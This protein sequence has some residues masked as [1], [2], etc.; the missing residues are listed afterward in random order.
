MLD[1]YDQSGRLPVWEL[2][3]NETNCMI[4]YHSVSVLAD[5]LAKGYP[6]D[7]NRLLNAMTATANAPVF[8]IEIFD[9][10]GFLTIQ[11]EAES[12]SKTLEYSYDDACVS[13]SASYFGMD[14]IADMYRDRSAGY[15]SVTNVQTGLVAPRDNGHFLEET[16]PREVNSHFTEANAWQYSFSP[17]HDIE[18]WL[19]LIG[20]G[21]LKTGRLELENNLDELFTQSEQTTGRDQADITGLIGQYA[22]GNEPSH[23]IAY[24]YSAT[25]APHKGQKQVADIIAEFYGNTPDGLIGNEDCGQMSAWYVMATMGIYPLVP[26]KPEYILGTPIWDSLKLALPNGNSLLVKTNG[27]GPYI[28]TLNINKMSWNKPW[29]THLEL[30]EGG[31][32]EVDR[33]AKPTDWASKTPYTTNMNSNVAAAPILQG[34]R[35]FEE[36]AMVVFE[37]APEGYELELWNYDGNKV[38]IVNTN[39]FMVTESSQ[40]FAS[41]KNKQTGKK[42]QISSITLTKKP[43]QWKARITEGIPNPQYTAGGDAALVDGVKGELDWRKGNWIGVQEQDITVELSHPHPASVTQVNVQLLKD[44]RSWIGLPD[45]VSLWVREDKEWQLIGNKIIGEKALVNDESAIYD[46]EW[47]GLNLQGIDKL[48]LVMRNPGLLP[49]AHIS[50]GNQSFIF[51]DEITIVRK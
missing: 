47:T 29:L 42:G 28:Q 1:Q 5:A 34:P 38:E 24:L 48:K 8:G 7:G 6:I 18:G 22:H 13:W 27:D 25:H 3:A 37:L 17:V 46:V 19:K 32:W 33:S 12:V 31:T 21:S 39:Q 14:S 4:G 11:D 2:A 49:E 23:H 43:T 30:L 40:Y 20:D 45:T 36:S 50:A 44:I 16:N 41:F 35:H 9:K 51:V 26:G 10:N 15:R